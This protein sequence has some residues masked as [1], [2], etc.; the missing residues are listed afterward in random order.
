[1]ALDFLSIPGKSSLT[2]LTTDTN[3]YLATSTAV[4]RV[5]SQG[6]H[7][8]QFTWNR[9]SASS[10]RAYLCL[11]SWSQLDLVRMEDIV[12]AVTPPSVKRKHSMIAEKGLD[13]V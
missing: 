4:E 6:R 11:G 1:M 2:N 13:T 9:L 10:I 3:N 12:D 7:L 5:F 8:L